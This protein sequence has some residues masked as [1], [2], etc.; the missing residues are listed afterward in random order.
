MFL[1]GWFFLCVLHGELEHLAGIVGADP[2][3]LET[4]NIFLTAAAIRYAAMRRTESR[5]AHYRAD[6]PLPD[7]DHWLVHKTLSSDMGLSELLS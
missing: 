7:D 4:R 6:F 3:A 5:G 1:P 2:Y